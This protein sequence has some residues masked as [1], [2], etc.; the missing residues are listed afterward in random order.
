MAAKRSRDDD[1]PPAIALRSNLATNVRR[2]RLA[3]GLKQREL[4]DV[5]NL[6][7]DYVVKIESARA[8]VSIDILNHIASCL[9]VSPIDLLLPPVRPSRKI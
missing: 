7:R 3:A 2:A 9:K 6:S 1:I 5:A 8:N 4:G